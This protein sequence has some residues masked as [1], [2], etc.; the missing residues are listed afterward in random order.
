MKKVP[1]WCGI[2]NNTFEMG[3]RMRT[4]P[5]RERTA[6]S[7][8]RERDEPFMIIASMGNDVHRPWLLILTK[9]SV[10]WIW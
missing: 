1:G 5:T 2:N 10:G 4:H 8:L 3:V 6:H 7:G 9:G